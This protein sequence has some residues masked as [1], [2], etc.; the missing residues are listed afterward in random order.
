MADAIKCPVCG[1]NNPKEFE[2]CQYCQSR[3]QP[4]TGPLKGADAPIKPGSAPTKKTTA[5]LEQV[6]PQWLRDAR[7]SARDASEGDLPQTPQ[8]KTSP[9]PPAPTPPRPSA[10]QDLLAGLRSQAEDEDE[11]TPDWLANITGGTPGSKKST[12]DSSD[13]RWVELGGAKDSANEAD[14]PSWLQGLAPLEPQSAQQQDGLTDWMHDSDAAQQPAAESPD[15]LRQTPA[16]DNDKSFTNSADTFTPADSSDTPDWLRQMQAAD[17]ATQ[18]NAAPAADNAPDWLNSLDS[19]SNAA[20]ITSDKPDWLRSLD[21]ADSG[22][23]NNDNLFGSAAPAASDTPDWLKSLGSPDNAAPAQSSDTPDWLGALDSADSSSQNNDALFGGAAT[24]S[25]SDTPDW[26]K[27]LGSQDNAVPAQSS[28]TPDWLGSLDSADSSSQNNDALFG[29]PATPSASDTPDWLKSLEST[30]S[31]SQNNDALFGS[32]ATPFAADTPDWLKS[33]GSADSG[34]QSNAVPSASE[35]PD[36]LQGLGSETPSAP[37]SALTSP[38]DDD[39]LKGM[40]SGGSQSAQSDPLSEADMPSWLSDS[41]A[42][43]SP[44]PEIESDDAALGDVPDW[45]KAA[46]PQSSIYD[47]LPLAQ[48]PAAPVESS[49]APD[50]L[51]AFKSLD[52]APP[53]QSQSSS[54]FD[55][56]SSLGGSSDALFTDMP[57]WLSGSVE[58][59]AP[60]P[61]SEPPAEGEIEASQLP[62]WVQAMR[63]VDTG[64]EQIS[65][66]SSEQKQLEARGAL[67]GLQGVL[68]AAP[69]YA[70]TSKPK[71]YSLKLQATDEQ[72]SQAALLE[73]ILAAEASPVPIASFSTLRSSRVLRW[74][75]AF[76]FFA[77][78][79]A[80]LFLRTQI[81]SLPVG[82]PFEIDGALKA[83]QSIP[84]GAPVLV[85]FDYE[86]ARVGEMEAAAAPMFDQM[87]LRPPRFTFISTNANSS[88]LAERFMITGPMA[89]HYK[90]GLQYL[91]LG[92]LP[93]GQMGIRAFV[94][95]PRAATPFD[96]TFTRAWDS[97][98]LKDVN[99]F[100][101]F[102]AFIIITDSA[103]SARAWIEQTTFE[104]GSM[105]VV[106]ISS[107]Q[108][109]PMIQPYYDSGQIRGLVSGL[110]GGAIFEQNNAGRPG[111]AR[112]YWDA[113]SIGMLI[114]A[115]LIVG[116]GLWNLFLGSR[117]RAAAT[118]EV[119]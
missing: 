16:D 29:S 93:G 99:S 88:I 46:A 101:N 106:V 112:I 52:P 27:S 22:S 51:N 65:A 35:T 32:A 102:A 2:F 119:K 30:D 80:I 33:L 97:T 9:R 4:L 19:Q 64:V 72:L 38:A 45:L 41:S 70:P 107:A 58:N 60:S 23:Q 92:Y 73:R 69:G 20:P 7:S 115:L 49:D 57:D 76:V 67:A 43:A 50:W 6:L 36:W 13:V 12:D 89:D 25:A 34:V 59:P 54:T 85:A 84:D 56:D 105:P 114:A 95:N 15:W 108:S 26:L 81:F 87:A 111:T 68:P 103:D 74:S 117:D 77:V 10:P 79:F 62:S 18:N 55:S 63:P 116:G 82:V 91:N 40:Q 24:P 39:W 104:R 100:S 94:Q 37:V 14:T 71:T 53:V 66:S 113:Y 98:Q 17:S 96:V 8:S 21:V 48:Q 11:E 1:E 110:Y 109:A 75:L 47:D 44:T 90:N 28:D 118:R 78:V 3:L 86:P 5:D 31:S 83:V 42:P 61:A